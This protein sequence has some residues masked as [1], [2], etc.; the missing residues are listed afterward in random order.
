VRE[1]EREREREIHVRIGADALVYTW[2]W[3]PEVCLG[4]CLSLVPSIL[5]FETHSNRNLGIA[6]MLGSWPAILNHFSISSHL[7]QTLQM[8]STTLAF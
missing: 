7:P 6:I 5:V 2:I 3:W 1:R 8:H 4:Y